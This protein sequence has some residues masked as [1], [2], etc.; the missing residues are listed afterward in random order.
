M[1]CARHVA[2]KS[3]HCHVSRVRHADAECKPNCNAFA[4][5]DP[6]LGINHPMGASRG[7]KAPTTIP[8][9]KSGAALLHPISHKAKLSSPQTYET[10]L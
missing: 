3:K 8:L 4:D 1:W 6:P 5:Q 2:Q 10:E 9:A 7:R